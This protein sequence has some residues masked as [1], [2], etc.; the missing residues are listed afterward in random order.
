MEGSRVGQRIP[1]KQV[2]VEEMRRRQARK[3]RE[4]EARQEKG[5]G[6]DEHEDGGGGEEHVGQESRWR[7]NRSGKEDSRVH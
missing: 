2:E 1:V 5:D 4:K 3:A 7:S 6:C